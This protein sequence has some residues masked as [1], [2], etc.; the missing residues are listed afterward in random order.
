[1]YRRMSLAQEQSTGGDGGKES[2]A[3]ATDE[4]AA[5]AVATGAVNAANAITAAAANA[6]ANS[7]HPSRQALRNFSLFSLRRQA[8]T[9]PLFASAAR[10][11]TG[12]GLGL[13]AAS[14][15]IH[16]KQHEVSDAPLHGGDGARGLQG[17]VD[18]AATGPVS[19][20]AAAAAD[21][22][23]D[24]AGNKLDAAATRI[25]DTEAQ[26]PGLCLSPTFTPS[27]SLK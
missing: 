14:G 19:S 2:E 5:A 26:V 11:A 27:I 21:T 24:A 4:G 1:M 22:A 9:N 6:D 3:T 16:L 12:K 18:I 8:G 10:E 15:T 17:D 25:V 20:S 13:S 23:G 7:F